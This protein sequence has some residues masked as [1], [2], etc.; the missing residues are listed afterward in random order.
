MHATLVGSGQLA[1]HVLGLPL[2]PKVD[3]HAS[4]WHQDL[5]TSVLLPVQGDGEEVPSQLEV[6]LD[7]QVPLAHRVEG[8]DVLDPIGV[9]VL[10]LDLVVVQQP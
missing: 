3:A 9:E 7:P 6:R 10:Q 2:P 4:H 8:R 1:G 5:P